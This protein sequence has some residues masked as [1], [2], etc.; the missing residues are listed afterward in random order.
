MTKSSEKKTTTLSETI[1]KG[2]KTFVSGCRKNNA[3][4]GLHNASGWLIYSTQVDKDTSI[5]AIPVW[6]SK[7]AIHIK[8]IDRK[9]Y[10]PTP[11]VFGEFMKVWTA[12]LAN[13]HLHIGLD[14]DDNEP[15][16]TVDIYDLEREFLR[17][18]ED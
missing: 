2:L 1:S 9:D 14:W 12:D 17:Q 11:I 4:W 8:N 10:I 3:M 5:L 18:R 16:V 15:H 13:D 6:S 7:E